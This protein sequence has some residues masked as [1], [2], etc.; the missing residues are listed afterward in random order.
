MARFFFYGFLSAASRLIYFL[1]MPLWRVFIGLFS[2][3]SIVSTLRSISN[4]DP[5]AGLQRSFDGRVFF[6]CDMVAK[7]GFAP[8]C[9][10]RRRRRIEAR[11]SLDG[12]FSKSPTTAATETSAATRFSFVV[13]FYVPQFFPHLMERTDVAVSIGI[14]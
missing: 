9:A 4:V 8:R 7:N 13:G 3:I 14:G 10:V 2:P 5:L 1:E 6:P 12:G 11:H